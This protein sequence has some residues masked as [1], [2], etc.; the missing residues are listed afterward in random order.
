VS[1]GVGAEVVQSGQYRVRLAS[2]IQVQSRGAAQ[3]ASIP[4]LTEVTLGPGDAAIYPNYAAAAEIRAV[5][6]APVVLVGVA[7]IGRE[8]SG[9]PAPMLPKGVRG[10]E[11]SRSIPS[12]WEKLAHGPIGMSVR[13]V[14]MPAGTRVGPYEPVGLETMR[15]ERGT[16]AR[17]YFEPGA[18]APTGRS[19]NWIEGGATPLLGMNPGMRYDMTSGADEPAELLVLIIEPAGITAQTLAP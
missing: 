18:A 4:E 14:T 1:G 8:P 11:L 13:Q 7:I 5:G 6:D 10:V 3:V 19:M 16:I 15:V 17:H 9:S 2:P 12:D